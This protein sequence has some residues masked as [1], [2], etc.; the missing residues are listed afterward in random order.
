MPEVNTF[1]YG[2]AHKLEQNCVLKGFFGRN[3]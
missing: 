1:R 2:N 3:I